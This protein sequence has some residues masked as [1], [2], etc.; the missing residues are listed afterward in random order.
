MQM[1]GSLH[2]CVYMGSRSFF[3]TFY[4]IMKIGFREIVLN[5]ILLSGRIHFPDNDFPDNDFPDNDFPD[6]DFPD[7]DF[8]DSDFPDSDFPDR[9]LSRQMTFPTNQLISINYIENS[10]LKI[11]NG[12]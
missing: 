3:R 7:N 10:I 11:F 5:K 1:R 6:S 12:Y 8:P 2:I 9:S 4:L